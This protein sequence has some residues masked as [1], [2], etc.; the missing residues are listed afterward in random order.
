MLKLNSEEIK[1]GR[2]DF[3][4]YATALG[5]SANLFKN[6][7]AYAQAVCRKESASTLTSVQNAISEASTLVSVWIDGFQLGEFSNIPSRAKISLF[8]DSQQTAARYIE[9]VILTDK[10]LKT[11]GSAFFES[12]DKM[13]GGQ[14]P[15]IHFDELTLNPT[16]EYHI[17]YQVNE[18]NQLR[19]FKITISKPS[20]SRLDGSQLPQSLGADLYPGL[21]SNLYSHYTLNRID[22]HLPKARVRHIG[23]DNSFQIEVAEMHMDSNSAHY[24]RYFI[25]TDPVGRILGLKKRQYNGFYD[26]VGGVGFGSMIVEALTEAQRQSLQLQP[27]QVAKINDCSY[28]QV[29]TEDIFDGLFKTIIHLA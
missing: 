29:F 15:Y 13:S 22:L 1:L 9:R 27:S 3:I 10:N 16:E 23:S 7:S 12:T 28:V 24:M 21:I 11:L 4:T 20:M 2:R 5:L 14:P 26:K 6:N 8:I 25:V 18:A 17:F 19:L